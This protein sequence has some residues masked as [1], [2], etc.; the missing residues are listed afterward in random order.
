V[1]IA[2]SNLNQGGSMNKFAVSCCVV[3][4]IVFAGCARLDFDDGKG[5]GLSYYDAKPYLFVSVSKECVPTASLLMLP[6]E[7]R[8]V[9]FISGMGSADLNL[10][11]KDGMVTVVGQ[12]TDTKI[13]ETMT[14]L[15]GLTTAAAGALA[16]FK[17]LDKS[18]TSEKGTAGAA[19]KAEVVCPQALLYP[20]ENGVPNKDA[21]IMVHLQEK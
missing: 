20:I 15:A 11:L 6:A 1:V 18:T 21:P 19:K 5:A 9:R 7:K 16:T 10:T 13:P 8:Q 17:T 3:A 14:S 4:A 12:K 2:L